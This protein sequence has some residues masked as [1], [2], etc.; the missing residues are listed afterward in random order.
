MSVFTST[1]ALILVISVCFL[2]GV[3]SLPQGRKNQTIDD[4][5]IVLVK[6]VRD[7]VFL[8][9]NIK[10]DVKGIAEKIEDR[11]R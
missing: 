9:N 10:M 7:M 8:L 3:T 11:G 2:S 6:I 5:I 1:Q 4:G